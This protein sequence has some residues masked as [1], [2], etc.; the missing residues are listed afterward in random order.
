MTYALGTDDLEL[1]RLDRQ[2]GTHLALTLAQAGRAGV[3]R[4]RV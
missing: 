2:A 1:K 4:R 3:W